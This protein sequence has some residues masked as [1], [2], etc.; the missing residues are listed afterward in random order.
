LLCDLLHDMLCDCLLYCDENG[1]SDVLGINVWGLVCHCIHG[2]GGQWPFD[3]D[4]CCWFVF[5]L[6]LFCVCCVLLFVIVSGKS[7]G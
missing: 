1:L 5:W 2:G 4:A 7:S 3:V 6:L